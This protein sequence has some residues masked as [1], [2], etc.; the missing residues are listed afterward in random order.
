MHTLSHVITA[1]IIKEIDGKPNSSYQL[2][3]PLGGI[4]HMKLGAFYY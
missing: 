4:H 3:Q 1:S 2:N